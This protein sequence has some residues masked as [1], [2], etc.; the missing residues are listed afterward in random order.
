MAD[1][2]TDNLFHF[3]GIDATTGEY[4]LPPLAPESLAPRVRGETWG[5]EEGLEELK[6]RY[7]QSQVG[8]FALQPGRDPMSLAESGWGLIL[9]AAADKTLVTAILDALAPLL[10]HRRAEAGDLYKEF[11]GSTGYRPGDSKNRFLARYK[12]GPG[13]VDPTLVPYYLLIVGDPES[14]PYSFQYELDVAY[15]VGRIYFR[16]LGEYANYAA[17]VVAAEK[18]EVV[19]PRR[20]T[21]FG[22][23]N[24]G[25]AATS[26]SSRRM[27]PPLADEMTALGKAS[28]AVA[29][30]VDTVQ[31]KD[32][33]KARLAGL[34]GGPDT[35]ALLFTASHGMG[36]P[37]GDPRQFDNQGALLCQDWPGPLVG[38]GPISPDH[39]LAAQDI[40]A[41]A[42]PA[43]LIAFF[44]ACYGAGTPR[45][46][47]FAN[48]STKTRIPIA[49]RAFQAALPTRLLGHPRG[50][51][52]AVVG[53]VERA[54]GY[55][56]QWEGGAD[57]TGS[58]KAALLQLKAGHR[59]GHALESLNTRYAEIAVMLS[60]LIDDARFRTVSPLELATKWIENNDA[61]GYA[62]MGDPAVRFAVPADG[63]PPE[64]KTNVQIRAISGA[65]LPDVFAPPAAPTSA[66]APA[67]VAPAGAGAVNLAAPAGESPSGGREGL[68]DAVKLFTDRMTA[69]LSGVTSLEVTT[70]VSDD[71]NQVR[72]DPANGL[73]GDGT[74][75]RILTRVALNGDTQVC[76]PE[77]GGPI[78]PA[79][80]EVHL[81]SVR[82]AQAH[83][84]AMLKVV[85]EIV[86][87]WA[88]PEKRA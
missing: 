13:P 45:W 68:A 35:P 18:G 86:S 24:P 48:P 66:P 49:P 10:A 43:G 38:R 2:P 83:R 65:P 42:S 15:A 29:W 84:V 6:W 46:D 75:Q 4:L 87:E 56:V 55:S 73:F 67:P 69:F 51:A 41:A 19:R 47:D 36:F 3:N 11:I 27:I 40:G 31:A 78:D 88:K 30:Q 76:V 23:A 53:H 14:I 63:Q 28:G 25:D 79:L 77:S 17:G 37:D 16:T 71:V 60:N 8:N 44:F 26:L 5:S 50:G 72:S 1:Q 33:K 70:F 32:A 64:T 57:Q 62:I 74:R 34:L 61:R 58:F 81:G 20:A 54:W 22:V 7:G 52:L 85:A 21:F 82:E 39:Y 80:W 59:L 12:A 9:P